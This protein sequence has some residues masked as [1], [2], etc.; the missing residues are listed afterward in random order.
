LGIRIETPRDIETA[1]VRLRQ[2]SHES[3]AMFIASLAQD[4]GPIGE[5]VRTFIVGDDLAQTRASL[6]A[7]VDALRSSGSR[8]DRD[9]V[10]EEGGPAARLHSG[11]S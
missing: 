6:E 4:V 2:R 3:L 8:D 9:R 11:C 7:R 10:G 5:Q 1:V